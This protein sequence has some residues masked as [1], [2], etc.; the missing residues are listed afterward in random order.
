MTTINLPKKG[1]LPGG[2][3]GWMAALL[4]LAI[5]GL[6]VKTIWFDQTRYL[7]PAQIVPAGANLATQKWRAISL[8]LGSIS[9]RYLNAG[10]R[11][12]GYARQTLPA[13]SLVPLSSANAAPVGALS[14]VVISNKTALGSGI[15]SGASVSI[16]CTP[17][18]GAG[19]F[20]A[21]RQL[22]ATATVS[23]VIKAASVFGSTSQ[24]VEVLVKPEQ[25]SVLLE[26][27]SSDSPLFLIAGE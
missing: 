2:A 11:P 15:H 27:I 21:P 8:N 7:V 4:V 1:A 10:A 20:D 12:R 5:L 18:L 17:K 23:K 6:G 3:V 22:V 24:Q 26:A 14:R 9:G 25:T 16:W 19:Q 13:G